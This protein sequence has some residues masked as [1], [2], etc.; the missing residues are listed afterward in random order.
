MA[1]NDSKFERFDSMGDQANVGPRWR[2]WLASFELYADSKGLIVED[3]NDR[4][5][6][7]RR[8]LLLH[9][10][11]MDVQDVFLT[12]D[13][14]G[15]VKDFDLAV[16]ALNNHFVPKAS[17]SHARHKFK[18]T[19]PKPGETVQQYVVRLKTAV[20]DCNY[21]GD[22]DSH[23]RDQILW[24]SGSEY[25]Q[26][27]LMEEKGHFTLEK[28]LEIAQDCESIEER[29]QSLKNNAA[30]ATASASKPQDEAVHKVG[31]QRENRGGYRDRPRGRSGKS[32]EATSSR[33]YRCDQEGHYGRDERCPARGKTCGKCGGP[34][35]FAKVC[36][37]QTNR[38]MSAKIRQVE[39]DERNSSDD[40]YAFGVTSL[41]RRNA[42]KIPV[43]LGG[44]TTPMMIDSGASTNIVN[45][46]TWR[47]LK[48]QHI[49]CT[50]EK[51]TQKKLYPY[52]S[53][54]SLPVVGTFLCKTTVGK[55]STNAEFVVIDGLGESLLGCDT[56]MKLG[57]LKMGLNVAAI[58]S[59]PTWQQKYPQVFSG[60][61]KLKNRQIKLHIDD[62]I[63]PV[64]QPL[65]RTPYQLREKVEE[66]IQELLEGDIIEPVSGPTP[67][68]NPIVIV[69]KKN[70]EI[71]LCI[72]MRRANEAI[73]RTR[74]PIPT[75][76]EVLQDM[77]G[78][79]VFTKLDLRAGY[80]QCE[81]D[82]ES[83]SITT[84]ATHIGL[85]R[86]K[87]LMFGVK[88]AAE[89]YQY[90]IQSA[91]MGIEGVQNISDDIIIHAE[92]K[93]T[94]DRRLDATLRRLH[95]C[96]LTLNAGK[97]QYNMDR[98]VF[99]GL[100][101]SEKGIGPTEDRVKTLKEAREPENPSE[102]RSFLGLAGFSARFIPD[103]ATE[104]E[105][106]RKLTRKNTKFDFGPDQKKSFNKLKMCL[107]NVK[108]LAY[109]D[110]DAPTKII[111]D[112]S[113]VGLGAV[114]VQDQ[115]NGPVVICYASRGLTDVERRYSQTEKE[116]LA[117]VWACERFH[118]Y[119]YGVEFDLMTDHK[120]LEVI[121]GPRSK[122]SARIERWVLRLQPYRFRIK[123][124]PGSRNIAD[125]LSRLINNKP[126]QPRDDKLK[127]EE[128]V[129]FVAQTA[130]PT[131]ISTREIER[132]SADD[133]E[134][135]RVRECVETGGHDCDKRYLAVMGE[136]CTVGKILLR[137]TRII[138]PSELRPRI[139]SLGH[140]GHQGIVNTKTRLRS[141]VWWPGME[142]DAEKHCK[143]CYSCQLVSRADP[144]EPI[145]VTELPKGPWQDVA[146]DLMGPFP[147]GHS[148]LVVVDYFSRYYEIDILTSTVTHKI[149]W[150]LE[151][152]FARHG[153]PVTLK[154]DNGPQFRADEFKTFCANNGIEHM[155]VTARWAQANGEVER[156]NQSILKRI[157]IVQAEKQDWKREINT[158]L[159]SS[160]STPH[161]T[162]GVSPAELLFGRKL[163]T[164]LPDS[165]T[166]FQSSQAPVDHQEVRDQDA[167]NKGKGKLA[168]DDR[169]GARYSNIELGDKVL[170]R[171]ERENKLTTPFNPT[172]HTV[173]QK[174]GNSLI[175]ESPEG[176]QYSRNSS[177]AKKLIQTEDQAPRMLA[178]PEMATV[179]DT[180]T[181]QALESAERPPATTQIDRPK[182]QFTLPSKYRDFIMK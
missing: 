18:Q 83:R 142:K 11:G 34:N 36:K 108:N 117:V 150:S 162:T 97:C 47:K 45:S 14:T 167:E 107:T 32:T 169:R 22:A 94:H 100:L 73:I 124:I 15:G 41:K 96:D 75:V 168:V 21:G 54:K 28:A 40:E 113:P 135:K 4:N 109:F 9:S 181:A 53:T 148:V 140:E 10:A 74:H 155:K 171:Q 24:Y 161:A 158:Y 55:Q 141:K 177:H 33:C 38:K 51:N 46:E 144:P 1:E 65:R 13:N 2:R 138:V 99:M 71:R 132:A 154:S 63:T 157:K 86:Y 106:L 126:V 136:L 134:L 26:R 116:A 67:W 133:E 145:R 80:H 16:T 160:R 25:M 119:V 61:G 84:F 164:K 3:G 156:Q 146:V 77:N 118:A 56:A 173:I 58:S 129:Q 121:Y 52:A 130:T 57:V 174:T 81:L 104:V 87:R 175:V 180:A 85:F 68:V 35:H 163:R 42:L 127:T 8:A 110:K 91:L 23:I 5:R 49:N 152:I 114:L 143:A 37:T 12:L 105:P 137:G 90:E 69:P 93:E 179:P 176:V 39:D 66:K 20:R 7:R 98:L 72:D 64:A 43:D 50:T 182:R 89:Q 131:A 95:E 147:S 29:M 151:K 102:V 70:D 120:P 31:Q 62:D 76:D 92:D 165:N 111:T 6:Q 78:S 170:L 178:A 125:S 153:L 139:L 159:L 79:K 88:S 19:V 59:E 149:I 101:L 44:V 60:V 122:P 115:K 27:R 103:F 128:Y 82:E 17:E 30:A 166:M 172:P 123:Y 112:A 48:Q